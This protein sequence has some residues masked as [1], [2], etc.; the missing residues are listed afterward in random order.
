MRGLFK[1]NSLGGIVSGNQLPK[2]GNLP[3]AKL[4]KTAV[5]RQKQKVD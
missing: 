2:I 1:R 3:T 5:G 4:S